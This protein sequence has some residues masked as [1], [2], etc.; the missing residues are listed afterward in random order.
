MWRYLLHYPMIK[1]SVF[2]QEQLV[3]CTFVDMNIA[4]DVFRG[5]YF[6]DQILRA[7]MTNFV[8]NFTL[9][10]TQ[11]SVIKILSSTDPCPNI[12]SA[13]ATSLQIYK[14]HFCRGQHLII[15]GDGFKDG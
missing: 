10:F 9:F 3:T 12:I 1:K 14:K 6:E 7:F 5:T 11:Y 2:A 15:G 8:T 4:K 13:N